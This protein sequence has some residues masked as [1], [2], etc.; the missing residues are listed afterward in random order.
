[1]TTVNIFIPRILANISEDYI[2]SVFLEMNIGNV[3][4]IDLHTRF[5][6]LNYRYSFAFITVQLFDSDMADSILYKMN[7]HGRAHIPYD[8][9]NYW[10]IKYF[11]PK[12]QRNTMTAEAAEFYPREV[13][14]TDEIKIQ[15]E[16][17]DVENE[18]AWLHDTCDDWKIDSAAANPDEESITLLCADLLKTQDQRDREKEFEELQREI[19]KTVFSQRVVSW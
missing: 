4:Y 11:I 16:D 9:R 18:P 6:E 1:M 3:T 10:E 2:K 13:S 14:M 19:N 8:D 7:S 12:E 15:I 17:D 5:N